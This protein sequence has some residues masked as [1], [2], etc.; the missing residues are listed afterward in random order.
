MDTFSDLTRE[1]LPGVTRIAELALGE[2]RIHLLGCPGTPP[3]RPGVEINHYQHLGFAVATPEHL[4]W[5]RERW[6]EL[7]ASASYRFARPEPPTRIVTDPDGGQ[8]FYCHDVNGLELEFTY[9][10]GGA[11]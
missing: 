5:W 10:P 2:V 11:R 6:L 3:A 7:F 1:R 4:R 8:S 9:L